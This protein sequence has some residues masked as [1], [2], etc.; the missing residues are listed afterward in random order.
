[1]ILRPAVTITDP[2]ARDTAAALHHYAHAMCFIARSVN[3]S[4]ERHPTVVTDVLRR[5]IDEFMYE[6]VQVSGLHRVRV[7]GK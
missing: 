2:T 6:F 3:F 7:S 1:V 5:P 4:I